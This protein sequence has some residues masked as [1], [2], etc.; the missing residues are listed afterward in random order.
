MKKWNSNERKY[1]KNWLRFSLGGVRETMYPKLPRN[2]ISKFGY[3]GCL[4]SLEFNGEAADPMNNALIPSDYVNDGCEGQ[5]PK[6][7]LTLKYVFT[8]H[9]S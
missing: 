2:I 7:L 6:Q 5:S 3:Q 4:A 9:T 8:L 1:E